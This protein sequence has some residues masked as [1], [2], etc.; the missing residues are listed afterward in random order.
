R[1]LSCQAFTT[2]SHSSSSCSS[3]IQRLLIARFRT[4][5]YVISKLNPPSRNRRP[6]S[7]AS[8]SPC[9]DSPTSVQPVKRFSRFQVLCPCRSRTSVW[10]VMAR[11]CTR[12]AMKRLLLVSLLFAACQKE[13]ATAPPRKLADA[14][15]PP[16]LQIERKA[17][18]NDEGGF[19]VV[20]GRPRGKLV[21][22]QP[23][24]IT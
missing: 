23:P 14:P 13:S 18:E 12:R 1:S 5:V 20:A 10:V 16:A 24:T 17:E 22:A 21:G 11:Q 2:G 15:P 8:R 7:R 3:A 6:A 9:G 19:R 4:E